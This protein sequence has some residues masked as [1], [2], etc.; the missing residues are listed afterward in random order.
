MP[1]TTTLGLAAAA[2]LAL[3][4]TPAAAASPGDASAQA[5]AN[6]Q[7]PQDAPA[8]TVEGLLID[9]RQNARRQALADA[10]ARLEQRA[11]ATTLVAAEDYAAG[12]AA[13]VS[14]MLAYA[15]GIYAQ[16]RHGEETRLSIRG[17][18][19]QR[20]F[21]MRGIQLY[22]DGVPL[23]LADGAGDFQ[24]IDP[25]ALQQVEVWRGANALEYGASTL[26]GAVNFVTPTGRTADTARLRFDAGSFDLRRGHLMVAGASDR[27]DGVLSVTHSEQEGWR[28]HSATESTRASANLGYALSDTLEARLYLTW[29]DSGF[30][31][32]GSVS[33]ATLAVNRR[34]AAP[35][36]ERL[37]AGNTYILKRAAARL[38]WQPGANAQVTASAWISDRDRFHPQSFGILDQQSEDTGADLRGVFDLGAGPLVRRLVVGASIGRYEGVETRFTNPNGNPG[39]RTGLQDLRADL[40]TA[41]AEYSHGLTPALTLQVGAQATRTTRELDNRLSPAGSYDRTF[42]AVSPKLGLIWQPG[43]RDQVFAN[44]SRSFE[45]APFGEAAVRPVLPIPEAQEATTAELGWRRRSGQLDLEATVYRAWIDKELLALTDA[46]GVSIGTANADQTYHQGVELGARLP[47]TDGLSARATYLYSDFR[48]DDDAVFGDKRLAG[49]APHLLRAELDWQV[50]PWLAVAP[51]VE[52]QPSG[53]WIDHANTVKEPGHTL[54]HLRAYG[55][56][57]RHVSW[58]VD[59]RNIFDREYVASTAVQANVLGRDGA[60]Y[61]VGDPRSVFVGLELR[62]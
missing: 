38:R 50:V 22:Q 12:R 60:Y 37:N 34:A 5:Q 9:G 59:A 24:A 39:A 55:A 57:N 44:V 2:S 17:S 11:G 6:P 7:S 21:L 25:L 62:Y 23:N 46:N 15:P 49:I 56:V 54:F 40:M 29:V 8:T 26:G 32:P 48:F 28:D 16:T 41:Y 42:E 30:E 47:L 19:I 14:D 31:L 27:L 10:L 61:F 51:S 3:S 45:P 52:W 20:G 18:G 33:R 36:N 58:F 13:T 43:P 53:V 35:N 1:D 4:L